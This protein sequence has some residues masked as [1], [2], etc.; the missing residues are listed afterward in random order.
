MQ[1]E[2]CNGAGAVVW[3][4][5]RPGTQMPQAIPDGTVTPGHDECPRCFGTG[6]D[7][8]SPDEGCM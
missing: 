6:I 3:V 4:R 1:C 7:P 5:C 2:L 8:V